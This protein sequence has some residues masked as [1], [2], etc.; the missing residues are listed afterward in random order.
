MS[1]LARAAYRQST[2][3]NIF[4]PTVLSLPR[5]FFSDERGKTTILHLN[6]NKLK[7]KKS[8]GIT[9]Y[10]YPFARI[11]DQTNAVDFIIIGDTAGSVVHGVPNL[12]EV[13]MDTMIMHCSAVARGAKKPFLIGDMPFLSY[14]P[15]NQVAIENAGRFNT[16]GMDAVK[17]EGY[18]PERIRA[19][20]EAGV[21]VCGHLGLTPQ[22]KAK[23]GG[24]KIQAKTDKEVDKLL[25]QALD[26]QEA[27]CAL[28][29]LEAVPRDV[30]AIVAAELSIPVFGIGAGDKVDG[31]LVIIHDI[32][33]LFW[34]FKPRFIKRY[35]N[36]E[37]VMRE[38]ITD[39][40]G[41]VKEEKFPSEEYF[42]NMKPEE[43]AKCLAKGGNSWKYS[44]PEDK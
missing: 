30:G 43:L 13:T 41:E 21:L 27:G 9:S 42:Y 26:V 39:Y 8:V 1:F 40:A 10:D 32:L 33:G 25:K 15:S 4:R 2:T 7:G 24:Y 29:L 17:M 37:K 6:Q 18:F 12:N 35:A 28:L 16:C 19:V 11:V 31:Q 3:T 44:K 22:T 20:N 5:R 38:A 14:Q 34:D 36:L 23:F